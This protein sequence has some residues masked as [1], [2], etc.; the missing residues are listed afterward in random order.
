MA[1][2]E[3]CPVRHRDL[4]AA[5][6]STAWSVTSSL[7]H[8]Q[9]GLLKLKV[10]SLESDTQIFYST[11]ISVQCQPPQPGTSWGPQASPPPPVS[12][13]RPGRRGVKRFPRA[14]LLSA[15][16]GTFSGSRPVCPG[17]VF[18]WV[19]RPEAGSQARL[20]S[21]ARSVCLG[22]PSQ[23]WGPPRNLTRWASR[24]PQQGQRASVA[25][26]AGAGQ[27]G[28][29]APRGLRR[30]YPEPHRQ[31]PADSKHPPAQA[32]LRCVQTLW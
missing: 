25:G 6:R 27:V 9:H 32:S 2:K 24:V 14:R 30:P 16:T 3:S 20:L 17:A 13:Q 21:E 22:G 11:K 7:P 15:A 18:L 28:Y 1:A 31:H 5:V 10:T 8:A 23:K 26:S 4:G 19:P 29:Q 12:Q